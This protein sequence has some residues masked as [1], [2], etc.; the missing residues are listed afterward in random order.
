MEPSK[1]AMQEARW[2][3]TPSAYCD[4]LEQLA[5]RFDSFAAAALRSAQEAGRG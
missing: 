1:E 2:A 3:M 4:D 5:R